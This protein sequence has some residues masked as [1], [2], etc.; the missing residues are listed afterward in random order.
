MSS[1]LFLTLLSFMVMLVFVV[2]PH[3]MARVDPDT[4]VGMWLFEEGTGD[5]A[6][7]TS[8]IGNDGTIVGPKEWRDGKFGQALEFD[9][10]SVYV[11]VESNKTIILEVL[12]GCFVIFELECRFPKLVSVLSD[13]EM[14]P[15]K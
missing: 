15:Q 12:D 2:N 6:K 1:K 10:N 9:G 14:N 5:V 11:E 7:Y 8:K 3:A 4:V 13:A